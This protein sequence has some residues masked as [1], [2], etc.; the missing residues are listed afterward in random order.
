MYIITHS[1]IAPKVEAVYYS[2]V[3]GKFAGQNPR[4]GILPG[5]TVVQGY[6]LACIDGLQKI[7]DQFEQSDMT[8][9]DLMIEDEV[10]AKQFR[11]KLKANEPITGQDEALWN[12]L[13]AF[14]ATYD[15]RIVTH[16]AQSPHLYVIW[17]WQSG[18]PLPASVPHSR[19]DSDRR[20]VGTGSPQ[21]L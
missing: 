20:L 19:E 3:Y 1:S 6:L 4:T 14:L 15:T 7:R 13:R 2:S 9:I 5:G 16:V 12:K 17:N 21:L 8:F 18:S 11:T 10:I